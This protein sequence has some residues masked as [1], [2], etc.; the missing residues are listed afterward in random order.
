M[1]YLLAGIIFLVTY[2]ASAMLTVGASPECR[3]KLAQAS[4]SDRLRLAYASSNLPD[5]MGLGE[6]VELIG[7]NVRVA[8]YDARGSGGIRIDADEIRNAMLIGC[9]GTAGIVIS[10]NNREIV[11]QSPSG[12]Q[13]SFSH[14]AFIFIQVLQ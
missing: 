6:A 3:L 4:I 10:A 8:G 1:K 14:Y 2:S 13:I 9:E 12:Q 7:K 5:L 11:I